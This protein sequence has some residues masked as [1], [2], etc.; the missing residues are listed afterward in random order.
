M[1]GRKFHAMQKDIVRFLKQDSAND[2]FFTT[3]IDLYALHQ[4]FPG[5]AEAQVYRS[6]PYLRVEAL[7]AS[8]ANE[9]ND[10]R[11]IPHIQLHEYEAYLFTDI[12]VLSRFYEGQQPAINRL[13]RSVDAFKSPELID[14]GPDTAPSKRIIGY[15]PRYDS[16]KSTVGVQA[17][18]RIGLPAIRHGCPHFAAWVGRLEGLAG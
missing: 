5:T 18:A 1:G 4:E 10:G 12:S 7:E 13:Q 16:D 15:L 17:A 8:W 14:E 3:M 9:T 6:D 11:F 2:A